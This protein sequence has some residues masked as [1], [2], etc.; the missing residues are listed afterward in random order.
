MALSEFSFTQEFIP[1]V[2]NDVADSLSRLY[3]DN[4]IDSPR[5]YSQ[6]R[7]Q[8]ILSIESNKPSSV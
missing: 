1:G 8:S 4:M 3:R 2:D 6:E 7:I 5:E